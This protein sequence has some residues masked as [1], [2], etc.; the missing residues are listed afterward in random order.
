MTTLELLKA[1]RKRIEDPARWTQK[2]YARSAIDGYSMDP[3][4]KDAVCWCSVGALMAEDC[5]FFIIEAAEFALKK[6]VI[7]LKLDEMGS[8]ILVNDRT[9][10][11]KVLQMYDLAIETE[12]SN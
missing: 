2:F 7:S 9:N 4:D 5:S 12:E 11:K 6:A 10:H 1:A 8:I 3:T